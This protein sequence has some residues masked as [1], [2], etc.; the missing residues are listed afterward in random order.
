MEGSGFHYTVSVAAIGLSIFISAVGAMASDPSDGESVRPLGPL[1]TAHQVYESE[2]TQRGAFHL[3]ADFQAMGQK[4]S[5]CI[6]EGCEDSGVAGITR[7]FGSWAFMQNTSHPGALVAR[8]ESRNKIGTDI[9]PE[10]LGL[11]SLGY[12]GFTAI[13]YSDIGAGLPEFYW[14]QQFLGATPVELRIGRMAPV[15]FFDVTPFSDNLTGFTNLSMIFSPTVTYALPGSLG[16]VGYVGITEHFYALGTIL[17]ANGEWD[18]GG[19]IG[20]G[21]YFK[22]LE[23]GWTEQNT[24]GF[25]LMDNYHISF[26]DKDETEAIGAGDGVSIAGSRWFEEG[27][28]GAFF[29]AGWADGQA[30]LEK[31]AAIGFT[32]HVGERDDYTGIALSW[33]QPFDSDIDQYSTEFFY[34]FQINKYLAVTPSLQLLVDPALND[35]ED[36]IWVA[37][38]RIRI[39]P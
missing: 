7:V 29:R 3:G 34:R 14:R 18:G 27:R 1:D 16:A 30:F 32:K 22:G 15:A 28:W 21:E 9:P 36:K 6:G 20:K 19:D 17:D 5:D 31:S 24:G 37:G 10:D 12:I 23:F 2:L 35:Q 4:T 33:G 25:Y 13:D 11:A 39:A 26:W 8:I 38:L